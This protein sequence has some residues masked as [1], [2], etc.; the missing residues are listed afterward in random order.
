MSTFAVTIERLT[1]HPHPGA[2]RLE[3]AQVGLY[4]AVVAKGQFV[5]GDYALYV[6]EGAVLP[7]ELI[8]ELGLTGKLAGKQG[9]RVKAVRLRGEISQGVVCR[10]K[11]LGEAMWTDPDVGIGA[12]EVDYA[13]TLGIT[14]WV[15]EVPAHMAG[16]VE[17]APELL[18]WTDI[19]NL[20]RYPDIFTPGEAVV[21]TEKIHGTCCLITLD[22][23]SGRLQV[24]SK[25]HGG[26]GLALVRS[27]TNLYWRAERAH[28]LGMKLARLVDILNEDDPESSE[29]VQ[30][31]GLFGE[32]YG[33]G[34]Q[35]LTYGAN[36]GRDETLGFRAFDLA[37]DS[38]YGRE[39]VTALDVQD[40]CA[41]VE[42][43]TVPVLY[44]GPFDLDTLTAVASGPTVVDEG[45]NIREG[46][47]I[48]S[49]NERR[50]DVTGGRAIAKLISP[51]YLLRKGP[52]TEFE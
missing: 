2:D 43:P 26:K 8:E 23:A 36:A 13:E 4:R 5:T 24:S 35:D 40:F 49:A 47:V 42:I 27:D 17:P 32:V 18:G 51:D 44:H 34:V 6:P 29:R 52:V 14:K 50:S 33:A 31:I 19:E 28:D 39:W 37:V 22:V 15:P 3:L 45:T 1:V 7:D 12:D 9:N 11:A 25:G 30:R 16:E 48:R 41:A 38:G 21:A 46:V 20:Q 10:P